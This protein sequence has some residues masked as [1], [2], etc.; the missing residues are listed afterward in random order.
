M[1]I[2]LTES[3]RT[4][5]TSKE[6]EQP[7]LL[8]GTDLPR[9][10]NMR[11]AAALKCSCD[12]CTDLLSKLEMNRN[13]LHREHVGE[14]FCLRFW[15][16][17]LPEGT[18]TNVIASIN[19]FLKDEQCR[20]GGFTSNLIEDEEEWARAESSNCQ[21]L[22]TDRFFLQ[23]YEAIKERCAAFNSQLSLLDQGG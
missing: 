15:T 21:S 2:P 13:A 6:E 14:L 18:G 23:Q 19:E 17:C 16:K 10:V 7:V 9:L 11:I 8:D 1:K 20:C 4:N 22:D 5:E 12:R 3:F